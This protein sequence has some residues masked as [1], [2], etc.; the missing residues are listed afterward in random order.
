VIEADES[1]ASLTRYCSEI[2]VILNIEKDHQEIE[3]L[4]PLFQTFRSNANAL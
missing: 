3:A 1:D 2:G 4:L